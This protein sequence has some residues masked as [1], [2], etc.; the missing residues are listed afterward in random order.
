MGQTNKTIE[1]Q[2]PVIQEKRP[3]GGNMF[4]F[5]LTIEKPVKDAKTEIANL[6]DQIKALEKARSE[7]AF[8][9]G[10]EPPAIY[11][12]EKK[13]EWK[14]KYSVENY[15]FVGRQIEDLNR[16]LAEKTGVPLA[17]DK[18]KLVEGQK[19]VSLDMSR[20][21]L[22]PFQYFDWLENF[23]KLFAP[24]AGTPFETKADERH[25]GNE[26]RPRMNAVS[27]AV[28]GQMEKMGPEWLQA[29]WEQSMENGTLELNENQ[30][31]M[32][33]SLFAIGIVQSIGHMER[34]CEKL[35]ASDGSP[36]SLN[37]SLGVLWTGV[38]GGQE[39][40][41]SHFSEN[42]MGLRSKSSMRYWS[43]VFKYAARDLPYEG[44]I[45]NPLQVPGENLQKV[46]DQEKLEMQPVEPTNTKQQEMQNDFGQ[47]IQNSERNSQRMPNKNDLAEVA[48]LLKEHKDDQG[49]SGLMLNLKVAATNMNLKI[50]LGQR[51][52]Q[53]DI[54][55]YWDSY[56]KFKERVGEA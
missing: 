9:L 52:G 10:K 47:N 49:I 11:P 26:G 15:V 23:A 22:M 46:T 17:D 21:K 2:M 4:L 29:D 7:I 55:E 31:A 32:F 56:K 53:A 51:P 14:E 13:A 24:G 20:L 39:K 54:D 45:E 38:V 12:L 18:S 3:T 41:F 30:E 35:R 28:L 25:W 27:S 43:N 48:N 40:N 37:E 42:D 50:E 44:I 1:E 34:A 19:N 6:Q 36:L 5:Q 8:R 33:K 16:L